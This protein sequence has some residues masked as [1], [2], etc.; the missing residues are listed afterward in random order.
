[1][2]NS[3]GQFSTQPQGTHPPTQYFHQTK[4]QTNPVYRWQYHNDVFN[5]MTLDDSPV[6]QNLENQFQSPNN[7]FTWTS[8]EGIQFKLNPMSRSMHFSDRTS[9]EFYNSN[10]GVEPNNYYSQPYYSPGSVSDFVN[11]NI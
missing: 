7:C 4:F 6:P 1:M 8:P 5:S 11:I 2:I 9:G 3:L 10:C